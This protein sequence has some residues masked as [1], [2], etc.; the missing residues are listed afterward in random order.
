MA[1]E[2][3]PFYFRK[4]LPM[5]K[6]SRVQLDAKSLNNTKKHEFGCLMA[7][8]P[9]DVCDQVKAW[10]RNNIPADHLGIG[11]AEDHIHIT[12][13]Y[14]FRDS[15][16]KT[17][18]GIK[19]YLSSVEP[20]P[21]RL[22]KVSLFEG[23]KDGDVLKVDIDS[24]KLH[25]INQEITARFD[26]EDKY[27]TYLPHMTLAYVDP[28]Y[29]HFYSRMRPEF[30]GREVLITSV[31]WLGSD[32]KREMVVLGNGLTTGRKNITSKLRKVCESF[33]DIDGLSAY[34]QRHVHDE[35]DDGVSGAAIQEQDFVPRTDGSAHGNVSTPA[36]IKRA[37]S[38]DSS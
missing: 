1:V 15:S 12:I 37:S 2:I 8:M 38:S 13:K 27:P 18:N 35:S 10:I 23:N 14:G 26:C 6:I 3:S 34:A 33:S 16:K 24:P 19:E 17:V 22:S 5:P 4:S 7:E 36:G 25:R 28:S 32:G 29:S 30:L 20:F 9:E 31:Q 21:V 11:G